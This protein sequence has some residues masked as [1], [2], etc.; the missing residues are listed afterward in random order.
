MLALA[1]C[2]FTRKHVPTQSGR[3]NREGVYHSDCQH[4][5]RSIVSWDRTAWHL[6]E[7]FNLLQL[8]QGAEE[9]FL[10]LVD[11]RDD[12]VVA[13]FPIDHLDTEAEVR[14]FS[15][16]IRIDYQ[17]DRLGN[18]LELR[19]ARKGKRRQR[20]AAA[21]T[22][23]AEP[24]LAA[25]D[26]DALTGLPGRAS[27]ET[28]FPLACANAQLRHHHLTLAVVDID[29]LDPATADAAAQKRLRRTVQ[30]VFQNPYG[31][32]NPRRKIDEILAEP[33]IIN[34]DTPAAERAAAVVRARELREQ[35]LSLR[36][37]GIQL[38][39][40]GLVPLRGG[41]WHPASVA[42]LLHH[43]DP[44]DRA[45]AAQRASELRAQGLSLREVGVRLAM[46]GH[47]PD[48]GGTW[49]PARVFALLAR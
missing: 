38:R 24:P 28:A 43:R 22:E 44:G 49:Y 14:A 34:T 41:Q 25:A 45:G 31:S 19:D 32:L 10:F 46:E 3:R 35:K 27:F 6:A 39:K 33:L 12:M 20:S 9:A 36:L 17:M 37:I 42:D 11:T 13:R 23:A 16:Q 18:T 7:G 21:G 4:C 29:G 47:V 15:Q 48:D 1:Q 5:R 30:I 2:W 8:T 40:E 26:A